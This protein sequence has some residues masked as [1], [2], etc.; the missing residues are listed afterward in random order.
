M[1][2]KIM[3]LTPLMFATVALIFAGLSNGGAAA[4]TATPNVAGSWEGT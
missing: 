1:P 4:G 2:R 3:L